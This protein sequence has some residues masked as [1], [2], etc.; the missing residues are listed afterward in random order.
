[1]GRRIGRFDYEI[2]GGRKA[3]PPTSALV[4]IC[5]A[6]PTI[7]ERGAVQISSDLITAGEIDL[8]IDELKKDLDAVAKNAKAALRRSNSK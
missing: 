2:L 4:Q 6:R 7:S 8:H 5:L 1:M 3:K